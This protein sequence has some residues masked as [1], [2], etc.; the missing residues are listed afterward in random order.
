MIGE[1]GVISNIKSTNALAN[2]AA[3]ALGK[4]AARRRWRTAA[5]IC[6]SISSRR[7]HRAHIA[8]LRARQIGIAIWRNQRG[9]A[10]AR[11]S[12]A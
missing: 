4:L 12:A 5:S 8:A 2:S 9:V 1:S 6:G 3:K 10:A 7:Q 11:L